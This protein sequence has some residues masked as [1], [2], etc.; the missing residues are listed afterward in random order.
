MKFESRRKN[1]NRAFDD[2]IDNTLANIYSSVDN[3]SMAANV[4]ALRT[5]VEAKQTY[6]QARTDLWLK[7]IAVGGTLASLALMFTF[8]SENV[9]TTKALGFIPKPKI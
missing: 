7:G 1:T 6:N 9:I 5:L 8:E 3:E 2:N 4:Q